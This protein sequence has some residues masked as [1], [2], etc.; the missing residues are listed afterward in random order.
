MQHCEARQKVILLWGIAREKGG[1][2]DVRIASRG[3]ELV[4]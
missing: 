4:Y 1:D 3:C 2:K